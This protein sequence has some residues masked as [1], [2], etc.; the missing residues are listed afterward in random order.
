MKALSLSQAFAEAR[1]Q[2]K[3]LLDR[4]EKGIELAK[5]KNRLDVV[6]DLEKIKEDL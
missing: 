2:R 1:R 6:R 4:I 3:E 5:S